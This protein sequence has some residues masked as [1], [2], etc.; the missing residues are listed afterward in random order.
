MKVYQ[1]LNS[2]CTRNASEANRGRTLIAERP[3]AQI[4]T[5]PIRAYN[6]ASTFMWRSAPRVPFSAENR[7]LNAT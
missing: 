4:R 3:P 1:H 2:Q 7:G 6:V 5:G